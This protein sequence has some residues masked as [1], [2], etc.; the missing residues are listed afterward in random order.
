MIAV[1][2]YGIG[3]LRSVQKAVQ[4]SGFDCIITREPSELARADK[5]ILPGVG[6]FERGIDN[7]RKYDL[8]EPLSE[9]VLLKKKEI[10]GICLGMQL[11]TDFSEEGSCR[12]LSWI[13]GRTKL[14]RLEKLKVPHIGWNSLEVISRGKFDV[15]L[16]IEDELYFVHSYYVSC[17]R[18]EDV[19]FKSNYE[20]DFVSG[21]LKENIMGVQ[22]HP[23]K[24]HETGLK[25]LKWFLLR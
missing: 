22:F 21:F 15:E 1:I 23:E 9:L 20:I 3:N 19:L 7:L 6:N 16:R 11:M 13:S 8:T 18:S 14:F 10:L 2:D 17:D 5:L 12:G 24:S 4:R 25:I